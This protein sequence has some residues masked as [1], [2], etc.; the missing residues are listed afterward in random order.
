M[1]TF[2]LPIKAIKDAHWNK[3][4]WEKLKVEMNIEVCWGNFKRILENGSSKIVETIKVK[5]N[6]ENY[7]CSS[8]LE[9]LK[10]WKAR[11]DIIMI[12]YNNTKIV[13]SLRYLV[14]NYL[15]SILR[16]KKNRMPWALTMVST[17]LM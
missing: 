1:K 8:L 11:L 9:F 2:Y 13:N 5:H 16:N 17:R 6:M 3:E 15:V 4:P 7:Q 12:P 10:R 14:K